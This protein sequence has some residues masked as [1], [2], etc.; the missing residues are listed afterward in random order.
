MTLW[1]SLRGFHPLQPCMGDPSCG[2]EYR[3]EPPSPPFAGIVECFWELRADVA[4]KPFSCLGVPDGCVDWVFGVSRFRE[5]GLTALLATSRRVAIPAATI[6]FGLRFLPAALNFACGRPSGE[7]YDSR[8]VLRELVGADVAELEERIF[9]AVDFPA[10]KTIAEA[11]LARRF[12]QSAYEPSPRLFACLDR[13]YRARG[14]LAVSRLARA[15]GLGERQLLRLFRSELGLSPKA[16]MRVVRFQHVL[17]R[18]VA[19]DTAPSVEL[20]L[21]AGY[22]DQAHL[23][24]EFQ[25]LCGIAPSSLNDRS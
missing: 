17:G 13:I 20:A 1:T 2:V 6:L 4:A 5:A 15:E 12:T 24:H 19:R 9:E 16:F 18:L 23:I 8:N 22:Y 21:D 7:I 14:N 25:A 3:E 11:W 10:R